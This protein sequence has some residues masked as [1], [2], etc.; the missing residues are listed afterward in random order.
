MPQVVGYQTLIH[1]P[2][3]PT[4]AGDFEIREYQYTY[5]YSG[6]TQTEFLTPGYTT[7]LIDSNASLLALQ[8]GYLTPTNYKSFGYSVESNGGVNGCQRTSSTP[9]FFPCVVVENMNVG[10]IEISG[11]TVGAISLPN[12]SYR[13]EPQSPGWNILSSGTVDSIYVSLDNPSTLWCSIVVV[14]A[15]GTLAFQEVNGNGPYTFPD[16]NLNC[17]LESGPTLYGPVKVILAAQY[18]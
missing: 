13:P 2:T 14:G 10:N 11:V 6:D 16:V 1:V 12:L 5:R 17:R 7:A 3:D 15:D 9:N 8:D 4:D 18:F